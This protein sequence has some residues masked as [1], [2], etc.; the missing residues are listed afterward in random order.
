MQWRARC[1]CHR[2]LRDPYLVTGTWQTYQSFSH[3]QLL[4]RIDSAIHA[5]PVK[6]SRTLTVYLIYPIFSS[7]VGV[8]YNWKLLLDLWNCWFLRSW[9]NQCYWF[10]VIGWLMIW[11]L[12]LYSA[13]VYISRTKYI[14]H[15]LPL[16][17]S[18]RGFCLYSSQAHRLVLLKQC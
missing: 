14:F 10:V 16:E 4:I 2:I 11:I 15:K 3:T 1:S 12:I 17:Y 9:S 8:L 13:N 6:I 18:K 5:L 7:L